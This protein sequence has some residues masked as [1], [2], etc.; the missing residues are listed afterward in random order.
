MNEIKGPVSGAAVQVGGNVDQILLYARA[1]SALA[2][3]PA[4]A[5]EFTGRAAA[6]A[7][8]AAALESPGAVVVTGPGGV[9]KTTFGVRAA[10]RVLDRFAGRAL[11]VNL[12]G[13][14]A[15]V[16]AAVAQSAFLRCLGVP[17]EHVPGDEAALA[18]LYRSRLAA[19][20]PTLLVL[21]NASSVEQVRPLLP[22]GDGHRVLITSRHRL[23]DLGGAHRI[24]LGVFTRT[25]SVA[26]LATRL[27][28]QRVADEPE[29]AARVG[30]LCGH[31]PLALGIVAAL[32][33]DDPDQPI[34][35]MVE[36]LADERTRLAELSYGEGLAVRTAFELSYASL[37]PDEARLFRLLAILRGA[38]ATVEAATALSGHDERTAKRLLAGLARAHMLER[39][40][41]RGRF[42]FHD[43]LRLYARD[44]LAEDETDESRGAA[45]DRL[46]AH[47]ARPG[48]ELDDATRR[49]LET[50]QVPL[51]DAAVLAEETGKHWETMLLATLATARLTADAD[52]VRQIGLLELGARAAHAIGRTRSEVDMIVSIGQRHR[53]LGQRDR[54]RAYFQQ[55]LDVARRDDEPSSAAKAHIQL[56]MEHAFAADFPAADT[57]FAQALEIARQIGDRALE[58]DALTGRATALAQRGDW[59]AAVAANEQG[60]AVYRELGH[61]DGIAAALLDL[62]G[63]HLNAGQPDR[64]LAAGQEAVDAY[65][66]LDEPTMVASIRHP[67]SVAARQLGDR[68]Q[69]IAWLEEALAL[70]APITR[71]DARR[72]A[73]LIEQTL[74]RFRE[75]DPDGD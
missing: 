44:R 61:P 46:I 35:E 1:P 72:R 30:E 42:H 37:T 22:G 69:A 59:A 48:L 60:L 12:H 4:D 18:A 31:L 2:G 21:D 64:V 8:V 51:T 70:L 67:M 63:Y 19:T 5:L 3:L 49:L 41:V 52:L 62:T 58:A 55:A 43:L 11:F 34:A 33:A 25:E 38:H 40:T 47:Y 53:V 20:E 9:G 28:D 36:V 73:G 7:A 13:Y 54:A 14:D 57:H 29:A 17:G 32:L 74:R 50:E 56:G 27:R 39:G 65:R 71:A 45:V 23:G 26:L 24:D 10:W 68:A 15:P 66:A 6:L 75:D 16:P